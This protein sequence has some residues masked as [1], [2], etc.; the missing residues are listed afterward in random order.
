MKTVFI[1]S[2]VALKELFKVIKISGWA[3]H[4]WRWKDV[5]IYQAE[6]VAWSS[7]YVWIYLPL[8]YQIWPFLKGIKGVLLDLVLHLKKRAVNTDAAEAKIYPEFK[9]LIS[10]FKDTD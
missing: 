5:D 3:G 2:S 1:V 4:S 9:S 6:K 8:L 7:A 10:S